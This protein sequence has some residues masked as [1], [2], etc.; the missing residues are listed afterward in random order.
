[1]QRICLFLFLFIPFFSLAD[2]SPVKSYRLNNGLVL[3]VKEVHRAPVVFSSVWYKVGSGNE[4]NGLTGISHML[5][6]MMFRGSKNYGPG[7]LEKLVNEN[8]GSQNAMTTNDY[9]VYYQFMPANKLD[10]VL[11]LEADRMHNLS[12]DDQAFKN[13]RNVVMQERRM[14]VDNDPQMLLYER[15]NAAA[16]VNNPY[17]HLPIGWM[18]DIENY[19]IQDLQKWYDTWYVPNNAFIV[20]V[21]DV[22]SEQVYQAVNRYFSAIK[23]RELPTL[24]PRAEIANLGNTTVNVS[25]PAQMP[26]VFLAFNTP[27]LA[28]EKNTPTPYALDILSGILCGD[29]SSRL[30]KSLVLTQRIANSVQCS[31]SPLYLHQN[32]FY[33]YAVPNPPHTI[34]ELTNSITAEI[35]KVQTNPIS[36]EEL[37]RVKTTVKAQK[38]YERDS[39]QAQ[40]FAI[41]APESLNLP[42]ELIE[43]YPQAIDKINAQDLQNAA[44]LWLAPMNATIGILHPLTAN[45]AEGNQ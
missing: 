41:G 40:A 37:E 29:N 38:I 5:E 27:T 9:T 17:H 34:Q 20:V 18:T 21:G 23:P 16:L 45:S 4:P 31:Y 11:Q 28:T 10:V 6:H 44:K 32:L 42:W 26:A 7:V 25:A 33:I 22:N 14:R 30:Q 24:K 19:T 35:K 36:A 12:L 13:E 15:L 1:M 43:N 8:G 2:T 3:Y 39:L